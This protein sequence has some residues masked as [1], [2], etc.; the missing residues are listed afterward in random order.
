MTKKKTRLEKS[1][2]ILE[3]TK[4]T[5]WCY[6]NIDNEFEFMNRIFVI[7]EAIDEYKVYNKAGTTYD[8]TNDAHMDCILVI[9]DSEDRL[10]FYNQNYDPVEGKSVT[11]K[12]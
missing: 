8:Y 2:A 6:V 5:Q 7:D 12:S 1:T 10:T 3:N 9:M 11:V 4:A